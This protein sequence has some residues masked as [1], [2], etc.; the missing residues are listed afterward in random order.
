MLHLNSYT[1]GKGRKD[2][3]YFLFLISPVSGH[4]FA[5]LLCLQDGFC[6]F[7]MPTLYQFPPRATIVPAVPVSELTQNRVPNQQRLRKSFQGDFGPVGS[8]VKAITGVFPCLTLG[9][10]PPASLYTTDKRRLSTQSSV[11]FFQDYWLHGWGEL[12]E[13]SNAFPHEKNFESS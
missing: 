4:K 12:L 8:Y 11:V 2:K 1:S 10:R 13:S 5:L 7:R 6:V 3:K 9:S